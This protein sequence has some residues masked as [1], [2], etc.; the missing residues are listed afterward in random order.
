MDMSFTALRIGAPI[1]FPFERP[2]FA[3]HTRPA[4]PAGASSGL[5][6]RILDQLD[7][8]LML[9]TDKGAV[10]FANRAALRECTSAQA[11]HLA[12]GHLQ[13]TSDRE[14]QRL[15]R[16][17]AA[18]GTGR[19]SLLSFAGHGLLHSLAV[20]PVSETDAV[21]AADAAALLVFGRRRACEPLSVEFFARQHPLTTAE[22]AVLRGLSQGLRPSQ[23]AGDPGVA[24]STVRTQINSIRLKTA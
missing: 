11:M 20:V 16:A 8:G 14:Q 19:R 4:E 3:A 17:L 7:Y 5:L 23:I 24:M 12:D 22:T 1:V 6:M 15:L 13:A 9:V 10:R 18:A 21:P 2:A